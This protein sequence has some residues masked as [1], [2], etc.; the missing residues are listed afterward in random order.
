MFLLIPRESQHYDLAQEYGLVEVVLCN[1]VLNF[2]H[3]CLELDSLSHSVFNFATVE[4]VFDC[5]RF[6]Y[7]I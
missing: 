2:F 3:A 7:G 5:V 1:P 6:R 4:L